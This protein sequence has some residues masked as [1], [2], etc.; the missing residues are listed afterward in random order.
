MTT[1]TATQALLD[2]PACRA[3]DS[4]QA[5]LGS[6]LRWQR[7]CIDVALKH[8]GPDD[9]FTPER[10]RLFAALLALDDE[11]GGQFDLV[12][13]A[14]RLKEDVA[15]EDIGGQDT[16]IT[17]CDAAVSDEPT[18]VAFHAKAVRAAA[19]VRGAHDLAC[20]ILRKT[21][22]PTAAKDIG[23]LLP[24]LV[25]RL[26][27]LAAGQTG[28][29]TLSMRRASEIE[30][31]A[32]NWLW[33]GRIP[34]GKL[35]ILLGNPGQGKSMAALAI[36]S[37]ITTGAGWPDAPGRR[38]RPGTVLLASAEDDAADT[39]VP[40]AAAAGTD[41]A[42]LRIIEGI[43]SDPA[44]YAL[45]LGKHLGA[46]RTALKDTPDV[47][48]LILDPLAAF[49][50]GP[51][52]HKATEVRAAL[53][54]VAMLAQETGVAILA[55]HHMRKSPGQAIH[56]GLGS[57]AFTAAARSVVGIGPDPA[58]PTSGRRLLV[59]VKCNLTA[60]PPVL[61]FSI[62]A[63]ADG[64]PTVLWEAEPVLGVDADMVLGGFTDG[65]PGPA[66]EARREAERFL[67]TALADGPRPAD[68]VLVEAK[69]V[70]IAKRT[71][72]R[73]R[74]SLNVTATKESFGGRWLWSQRPPSTP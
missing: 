3:D 43:G 28:R 41:L 35:T 47:R 74:A 6:C 51:D 21:A 39:I 57:I 34:A 42:R 14:S 2:Q 18:L 48:L 30:Q 4:E 71:L 11:T 64:V 29:W 38:E 17:L 33:P 52:S 60:P 69:R 53:A 25:D 72:E 12:A 62:K 58:D 23:T 65:Q 61:A 37:A 67:E 10:Q 1:A 15:L 50:P 5:L 22:T 9:F 7:P 54:P 20:S 27:A 66:P 16:L 26:H 36:A 73:A 59:P 32:V 8:V 40:R 63:N 70:G 13:M 68:E 55:I 45:D 56:R 24:N 44:R 19:V 31:Q 46:V 49:M